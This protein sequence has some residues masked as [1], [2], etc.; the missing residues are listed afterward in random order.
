MRAPEVDGLERAGNKCVLRAT[1][2]VVA[3]LNKS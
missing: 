2:I 1:L 3:R